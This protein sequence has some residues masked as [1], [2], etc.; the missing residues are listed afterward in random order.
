MGVYKISDGNV[1]CAHTDDSGHASRA[2]NRDSGHREY[3]IEPPGHDNRTHAE[4]S[5]QVGGAR[6]DDS[7]HASAASDASRTHGDSSSCQV[8]IEHHTVHGHVNRAHTDD[9]GNVNPELSDNGDIV[10]NASRG[11][12]GRTA[13][14]SHSNN[15]D[16]DITAIV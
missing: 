9:D 15:D 6:A 3:A 14:V 4:T 11:D 16:A 12:D 5:Y 7:G 1:N 2:F 8:D 13:D 10:N